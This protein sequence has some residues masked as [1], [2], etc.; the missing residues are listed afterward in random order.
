MMIIQSK[1]C[2]IC[3][4]LVNKDGVQPSYGKMISH[5]AAVARWCRYARE[6]KELHGDKACANPC[7]TKDIDLT[8][9]L[10]ARSLGV[11]KK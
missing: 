11:I 10:E 7:H 3:L 9:T 6:R 2:E 4:A 5:S 8:E 1:R